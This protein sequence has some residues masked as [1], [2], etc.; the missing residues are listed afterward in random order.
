MSAVAKKIAIVGHRG[1]GKTSFLHR[2]ENAYRSEGRKL[3]PFDLDQEIE[4]NAGRSIHEI[5]QSDGEAVFRR[6]EREAFKKIEDEL[7]HSHSES[8]VVVVCGAGFD[9]SLIGQ[10]WHVLWLRRVT[11]RQGRIFTNRPR[12]NAK[13]S[14]LDE[15]LERFER[16]EKLYAERADETLW[17]DEGIE[18]VEDPAET[19]FILGTPSDVGG[20]ITLLP[21]HFS[22]H[23]ES[24]VTQ[25]AQW[26]INWF[27]LRDDLLT[28]EQFK[29]AL[30]HIPAERALLSFRDPERE[31]QTAGWID[32]LGLHYDW[33][34]ER[35]ECPFGNPRYLSL[36]DRGD[37]S[38]EDAFKKFPHEV[39][40]GT[41]L[42]AA[43][44]IR[45]LKEL[46]TAHR[47]QM[48]NGAQRIFLPMS[49][50]GRWDWYRL[51]RQR[52]YSLNFVRESQ[53]SSGDQPTLLKWLR[54]RF[55]SGPYF[56]AVLGDPVSHSR[57]PMEHA[58]YFRALNASVFGI[59]LPENEATSEA[60][61]FLRELGLRWAAVT[62]PLKH[63]AFEVCAGLSDRAEEL[64]SVNTLIFDQKRGVWA[65]TNTDFD[66][67]R[68]AV[69]SVEKELGAPI[70]VWG[71]G[72]TL[73]VVKR[74]LKHA[75]LFS[76][77]TGEVRDGTTTSD[78]QPHAVIWAVG[79][80]REVKM[81]PHSWKPKLVLDL[82][83]SD[84]S[85]GREYA[86]EVGA[87]YV[88]GLTM[89]HAQAAIQRS[90]WTEAQEMK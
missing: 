63:F 33:P 32:R 37:G 11:D 39:P 65:G 85:P 77:R 80:S 50:N 31:G 87:R 49:E 44:P 69:H 58:S 7:S 12:L 6:L 10:D 29:L 22:N 73:E 48:A 45:S 52:D 72:G 25:R 68:E 61:G 8:D 3:R 38:L 56:A 5:F 88:S 21:Q 17:L 64:R 81:P 75:D 76:A 84:D 16:R 57:T 70:A 89:F 28:P 67:F 54:R 34:V 27:E 59:Q 51:L 46:E 19:E 53:G 86:L 42:K 36:H 35:G 2:F 24:W 66:G 41:Q 82:N 26:G 90:F 40:P 30:E 14:P 43:L 20:A 1:T 4:Q 23:F 47:W 78:Y 74:V 15:F 13:T 62:A 83:Y 9:P 18:E 60:L 55:V 79:R 71:G